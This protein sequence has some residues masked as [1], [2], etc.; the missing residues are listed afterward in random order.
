[1]RSYLRHLLADDGWAVDAVASVDAALRAD[2]PD[3]VVSD[4]M[5]P[6]ASGVDL[7]RM[8]RADPALRRIPVILLT[9]RTGA[10]SA[11][12]GLRWGADDYIVK[13]FEPTELLARVRVHHELAQLRDY[14]L[15]EAENR[16]NNLRKA[17]ASNRQIGVAL[18]VLMAREKL[19]EQ[20]AFDRL[21]EVSQRENRKLRDVADDV[22]LTGSLERAPSED[23]SSNQA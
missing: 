15:N 22:V 6:G 21:R 2:P 3:L 4:V 7:L 17:L 5:L 14:A 12:E 11:A 20:Q 1:M 10:D 8:L 18:G 19:T 13:P 16:E 9:A 23:P